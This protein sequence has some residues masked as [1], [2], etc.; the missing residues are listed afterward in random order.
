ML[1]LSRKTG[2]KI[3][4]NDNIEIT[5][6]SV[7]G[8]QVRLGIVAPEDVPIHRQEVLAKIKNSEPNQNS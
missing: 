1:V 5:V 2:E 3:V 8:D 6:V 4:I 7:K